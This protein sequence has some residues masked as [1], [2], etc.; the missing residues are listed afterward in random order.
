VLFGRVHFAAPSAP[1]PVAQWPAEGSIALAASRPRGRRV[2]D[3]QGIAQRCPR[4]RDRP[5]VAPACDEAG[6][7]LEEGTNPGPHGLYRTAPVGLEHV[8]RRRTSRRGLAR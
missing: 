6:L 2:L 7:A 5:P 8:G 3:R 1:C 4:V